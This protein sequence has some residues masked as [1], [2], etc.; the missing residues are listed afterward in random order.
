MFT[1]IRSKNPNPETP[2]QAA[3]SRWLDAVP[4]ERAVGGPAAA[5]AFA[6]AGLDCRLVR[7]EENEAVEVEVPAGAELTN[8]VA[9]IHPRGGKVRIERA[10]GG[11]AQELLFYDKYAHYTRYVALPLALPA[12]GRLRI[13]QLPGLPDVKRLKGEID[14]GSRVGLLAFLLIRRTETAA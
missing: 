8:L 14:H 13:S 10:D 7:V 4:A 3:L 12:A 6:R 11:A 1:L 9:M 5:E 2:P